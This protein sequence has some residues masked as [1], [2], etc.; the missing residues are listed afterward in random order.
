VLNTLDRAEEALS[1]IEYAMRLNPRYPSWYLIEAGTAYRL[2]WRQT[3]AIQTLKTLLSREP[4][5]LAAYRQMS[6]CYL[7]QY[8]YQL[9][10][11]PGTLEQALEAA[12]R[13]VSL[14]SVTPWWGHLTLG[15]VYLWQKHYDRAIAEYEQA[16]T[17][18]P[19]Y[20]QSYAYLAEAFIRS[21]RVEEAAQA[22]ETA[23]S[24]DPR[25][26][27]ELYFGALGITYYFM[28]RSEKAIAFL[29]SHRLRNP[30]SFGSRLYLAAVYAELGRDEETREEAA[31]LL[32]LNPSFS[33]AVYRQRAPLKDP[34]V[35]DRHIAALHKA[36]LK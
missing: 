32:R 1:A 10:P 6:L 23:L 33:L 20:A 15:G 19:T 24:L 21:G 30:C 17:L 22:V 35:L 4:N 7:Q 28:G 16:V 8:G 18:N 14:S 5:Y 2:L 34:A 36:G 31:E 9:S 13:I 29:T 26:R 3:E 11:D 25:P 12:Q 27:L